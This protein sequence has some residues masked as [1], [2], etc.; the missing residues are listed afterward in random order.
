MGEMVMGRILAWS[1]GRKKDVDRDGSVPRT[2]MVKAKG[3]RVVLVT[4]GSRSEAR[5]I[6]NAVVK[7][8][9]AACVNVLGRV[10]SIYRWKGKVETA[11]E[12]LLVMKT[13]E[14]RLAELEKEVKR[15]HSYDV[16]EFVVVPVAAGSREYLSWLEE[17]VRPGGR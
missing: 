14:K 15:Q 7:K 4:C 6:G 2:T 9:L 1:G 12:M 16:P 5:R 17:S 8:R 11:V 3:I 10:E 13:T